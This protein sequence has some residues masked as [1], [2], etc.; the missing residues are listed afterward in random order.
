M[1]SRLAQ[2]TVDSKNQL[3]PDEFVRFENS[4]G[5]G[6]RAILQLTIQCILC[7]M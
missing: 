7:K 6:V 3:K 2:N 4:L 5:K 1:Y